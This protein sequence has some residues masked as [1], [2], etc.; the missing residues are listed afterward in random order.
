MIGKTILHYRITEALGEGGMGVV[1]KAEDTR[2]NRTVAL[3][4][5]SPGALRTDQDRR[6]LLD[7]ARAAASVDHP[8]LC[9]IYGVE[10]S[11]GQI[12]IA[13]QFLSGQP[14][15]HRIQEGPLPVGETS[16]IVFE[17]AEGLR[18]AHAAGLI[19]RDVKT[20]NIMLTDRGPVLLDFG[21]AKSVSKT[22][23]TQ[24]G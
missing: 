18:A 17:V 20:A 24:D 22:A 11:E 5:L 6:R 15:D 13:M 10:E 23:V 9:T 21:L 7:E 14:L 3:K 4:F 16:G 19:H 12:F 1:Y 8:R 2:L